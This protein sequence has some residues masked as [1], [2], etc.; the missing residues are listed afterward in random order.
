MSD[1]FGCDVDCEKEK[2]LKG[3][4][5]FIGGLMMAPAALALMPMDMSMAYAAAP[6]NKRLIVIILRGGMDGLAAAI[7]YGDK[8]YKNLRKDLAFDPDQVVNLDGFFALHPAFVNMNKMYR[9]KEL[10]SVHALASPYRKRSHFD[11]QNVLELGGTQPYDRDSGWMN[12]LVGLIANKLNVDADDMGMS[13]GQAVPMAMRGDITL[14][15]WAPS[16]LPKVNSDFYDFMGQMYKNDKHLNAALNKGVS[17]QNET[18]MLFEGETPKEMRKM[19]QQSR[20]RNGFVTMAKATGQWMAEISGPRIATLE[21]GGWD[22]HVNQGTG[23]G[24]LASNFTLLDNGIQAIKENIGEG[25]WQNTVVLAVTEF[26]RTGA[27]NGTNGTDHGMGGCAFLAGGSV[28]G[29]K[30]IADWPGLSKDRLYEARDLK[31]TTDLRSIFKGVIADHYG[32]SLSQINAV[33]YPNSGIAPKM[34]DL[35]V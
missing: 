22:T 16:T 35:I 8:D 29:G 20:N 3:R 9:D 5:S 7:P 15:S 28:K 2:I 31:P 19:A 1:L 11:A 17:I 18:G 23:A 25:A 21:L 32:L 6:T 33:I 34:N 4:R 30:V 12:R 26:G 24:R 27:P 10:A 13:F 14:G